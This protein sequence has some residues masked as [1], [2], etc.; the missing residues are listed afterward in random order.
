MAATTR[1]KY[2]LIAISLHWLTAVLII[3]MLVYGEDLMDRRQ[4]DIFNATVHASVGATILILSVIRLVWRMITPVPPLP[5]SMKPWEVGLS[6]ATHAIFYVM[7]I[8][9]P[10]TGWLAF[11]ETVVRHPGF[12]GTTFFG[13]LQIIQVAAAVDL[14]FGNIHSLGSNL[15]IALVALHVLAALKHQFVDKDNLLGRMIP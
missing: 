9:L 8:G 13:I 12:E 3:F 14:P 10:I 15:M 2:D 1:T 5:A 4:P 7:M 11:S 6:K